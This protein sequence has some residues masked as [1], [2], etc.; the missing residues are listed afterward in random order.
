MKKF[1]SLILAA[2][3][4]LSTLTTAFAATYTDKDTVK[5]VQQALN[6]AGYNCGTPDGVAGK[7]TAV[8]ITQYRTERGWKSPIPSMTRCWRPWGWRRQRRFNRQLTKSKKNR[9]RRKRLQ[10][11]RLQR[12]QRFQR[13]QRPPR[14][15]S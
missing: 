11:R 5:K 7:K 14:L 8:A 10:R 3:L 4:V 15:K 13:K 6:D 12:K 9:F 1:I 2:L